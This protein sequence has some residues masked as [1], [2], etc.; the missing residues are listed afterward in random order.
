MRVREAKFPWWM[1]GPRGAILLMGARGAVRV[2]G[3]GV[4]VSCMGIVRIGI[5]S[6]TGAYADIRHCPIAIAI[7]VMVPKLFCIVRSE[8][9]A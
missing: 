1:R 9:Y 2:I 8:A 6:R 3:R 4:P 5:S 7:C